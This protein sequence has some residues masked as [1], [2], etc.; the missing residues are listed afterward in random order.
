MKVAKYLHLLYTSRANVCEQLCFH[1]LVLTL[2]NMQ[3]RRVVAF[4]AQ[5]RDLVR[6]V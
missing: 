2:L 3:G 6:G 5:S 1:L 4:R